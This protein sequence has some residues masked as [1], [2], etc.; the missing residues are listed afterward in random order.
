LQVFELAAVSIAGMGICILSMVY[1]SDVRIERM[2]NRIPDLA[3]G[4]SA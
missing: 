3:E 1:K 2:E 4:I